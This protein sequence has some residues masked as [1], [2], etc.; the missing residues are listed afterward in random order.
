MHVICS[1]TRAYNPHDGPIGLKICIHFIYKKE[2]VVVMM[3]LK[4][5]SLLF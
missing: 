2:F 5:V 1:Y 4:V 3:M